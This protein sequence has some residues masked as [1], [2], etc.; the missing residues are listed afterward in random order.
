MWCLSC[1]FV[2]ACNHS[3]WLQALF[4]HL[5]QRFGHFQPE[6][7]ALFCLGAREFY[8]ELEQEEERQR[9]RQALKEASAQDGSSCPYSSLL[10]CL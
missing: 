2:S 5:Q 6:D 4:P 7:C 8:R 3:P 9:F 10:Q 1:F